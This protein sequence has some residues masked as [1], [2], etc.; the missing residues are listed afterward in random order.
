MLSMMTLSVEHF[1]STTHTKHI[2]MSQLQY[3]RE[4][5]TS[6]KESLKRVHP[7]SV[8]Y[9]TS[10]KGSWYPPAESLIDFRELSEIL[11]SRKA[12]TNISKSDE[13]KWR[14]WANNYTQA[15]RKQT[16]RQE[17]TMAKCGTLPSYLYTNKTTIAAVPYINTGK[18]HPENKTLPTSDE[19]E[20]IDDVVESIEE[21]QPDIFEPDTD[22]DDKLEDSTSIGGLDE[23]SKMMMVGRSIRFGRTIKFNSKF[24]S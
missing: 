24:I 14:V 13:K 17:T 3:A 12:T 9:F 19:N 23:A 15:V 11:P 5:M 16:V 4:F 20:N 21:E 22:S 10:R 7:W 8:H 6:V 2:L 18:K 1:H